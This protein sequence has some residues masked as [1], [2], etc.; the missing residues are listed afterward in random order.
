MCKSEHASGKQCSYV[1]G[2]HRCDQRDTD[3]PKREYEWEKYL[4]HFIQCCRWC[5]GNLFVSS[6]RR[7]KIDRV[8]QSYIDMQA[9]IDFTVHMR[10]PGLRNTGKE[11]FIPSEYM[12]IRGVHILIQRVAVHS[13]L[14]DDYTFHR[15]WSFRTWQWLWARMGK[16]TPPS[17]CPPTPQCSLWVGVGRCTWVDRPSSH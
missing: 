5:N 11:V 8:F 3:W 17:L 7:G 2:Q 12:N 6:G 10:W 15:R 13:R 4:F 1:V 9:T 16:T 14:T